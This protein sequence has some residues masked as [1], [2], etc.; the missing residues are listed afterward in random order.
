MTTTHLGPAEIREGHPIQSIN[1]RE[2]YVALGRG[3]TTP[4]ASDDD[5]LAWA[6]SAT[7]AKIADAATEIERA[8]VLAWVREGEAARW[9]AVA[10]DL[11]DPDLRERVHGELAPCASAE[12]VTR[13]QELHAQTFGAPLAI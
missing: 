1:D 12:F 10:A 8:Q 5:T 4:G 2:A 6:L 3:N 9:L 7:R 11:M 13:Y